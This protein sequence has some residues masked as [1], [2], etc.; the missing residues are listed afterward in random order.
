MPSDLL[1]FTPLEYAEGTPD[2]LAS[3]VAPVCNAI[4]KAIQT[5]RSI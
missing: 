5:L 1:G 2:T 4:R 3:R